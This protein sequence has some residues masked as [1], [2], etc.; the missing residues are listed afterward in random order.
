[1]ILRPLNFIFRRFG[2]L[3]RL[4][5]RCL[6]AYIVYEDGTECSETS[7]NKIQTPGSNPKERIQHSEHGESL[8]SRNIEMS[9][10]FEVSVTVTVI[11]RKVTISSTDIELVHIVLI[12]TSLAQI[13]SLLPTRD[14]C[15]LW[16]RREA[17]P[18]KR[19]YST[20]RLHG[21]NSQGTITLMQY[22]TD[23]G[24]SRFFRNVGTCLRDETASQVKR[25]FHTH[26]QDNLKFI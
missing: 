3:F 21:V 14:V 20:A 8:K 7:K 11:W 2:T 9:L 5:R 15:V 26:T 19:Q 22:R 23:I 12:G 13:L 25:L 1:M 16:W 24:G 6:R 17:V 18:V 4:H 10:Q